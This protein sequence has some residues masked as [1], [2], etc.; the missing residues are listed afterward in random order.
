[1]NPREAEIERWSRA[2]R[3]TLFDT[4]AEPQLIIA[5]VLANLMSPALWAFREKVQA[6]IDAK[7]AAE[8]GD[9]E[10]LIMEE[11]QAY[12]DRHLFHV[13]P[14][15]M[16]EIW[17][18]VELEEE[19]CRLGADEVDYA[20]DSILANLRQ[21][22]ALGSFTQG[23]NIFPFVEAGRFPEYDYATID[24]IRAHRRI[25]KQKKHK[26]LGI[27]CCVDEATLIAALAT[28]LHGV[29]YEELIVFGAPVHY[30]TFIN[31]QGKSYWFNGKHEFFDRAAWQHEVASGADSGLQA[32]FDKRIGLDRIITPQG[33]HLFRSDCSS[34]GP[35]AEARIFAA[36][37]DFFGGDL[38]QVTDARG[39]GITYRP[40]PHG[41]LSFAALDQVKDAG[42]AQALLRDLAAQ[43]PGSVFEAALYCHRDLSVA[44]P[45]AYLQA[46][47]RGPKLKAAAAGIASLE[48]ALAVVAGIEGEESIFEDRGRIALPD[49][50]LLFKTGND[51]ERALLLYSLLAQAGEAPSEIL[52]TAEDSFLLCAGRCFSTRSMT[53]VLVP[54]APVELR[55]SAEA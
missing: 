35:E 3:P 51:R 46:A 49:E 8:P 47:Q 23:M 44:Q 42:K 40:S 6:R 5:L 2:A 4:V 54:E 30:A 41:A 27:T 34:L 28:V 7:S 18:F 20:V 43:H 21:R 25:L 26:P 38:D 14:A 33:Q 11:I 16:G 22:Q 29:S 48:D 52:F 24:V 15:A 32:A 55:L 1:M 13:L 12:V 50:V 36:L 17:G 37:T 19:R 9:A 45:E 53:E 39:R 10:S 31:H